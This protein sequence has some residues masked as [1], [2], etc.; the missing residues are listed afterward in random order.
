MKFDVQIVAERIRRR[1]GELGKTARGISLEAGR[2][3]GTVQNILRGHKPS[4]DTLAAIADALDCSTEWLIGQSSER[5][6]EQSSDDLPRALVRDTAAWMIA[7]KVGLTDASA[8][9]QMLVRLVDWRLSEPGAELGDN[10][11]GL[12]KLLASNDP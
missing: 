9:G 8:F 11:K 5:P 4:Y 2:P 12:I 1:L 3:E 10:V 7:N 6:R